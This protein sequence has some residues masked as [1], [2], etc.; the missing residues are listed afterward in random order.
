M[1]GLLGT[2]LRG[3]D[4]GQADWASDA[5]CRTANRCCRPVAST[6]RDPSVGHQQDGR[7]ADIGVLK[8]PLSG[9]GG[10]RGDGRADR[11]PRECWCIVQGVRRGSIEGRRFIGRAASATRRG[12]RPRLDL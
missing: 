4:F 11:A 12:Q 8:R 10:D 5:L 1:A 7:L 9:S 6:E 3:G 2:M